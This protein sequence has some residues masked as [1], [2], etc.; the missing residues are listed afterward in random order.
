MYLVL[1]LL[2]LFL[3][4]GG[5]RLNAAQS[6]ATP[7][8]Y[9]LFGWEVTNFMSK[10]LN[11]VGDIVPFGVPTAEEKQERVLSFFSLSDDINRL[12]GELDQASAI[13]GEDARSKIG[14]VQREIDEVVSRRNDIKDEIEETIE[15][16]ISSVVVEEGLSIF[17]EF[18]FPPVDVRLS[19]PP[20]LLVTS[21]RDRIDRTHD[22]L[23]RSSVKVSDRELIEKRLLEEENL[24]AIVLNI[25]GIATYPASIPSNQPLQWTLQA[26]AHEWLHHYFFFRPLGANMFNDSDMVSL[27]ETIANLTGKEIG[28]RAY[29]SLGGEV[30]APDSEEPKPENGDDSKGKTAQELVQELREKKFDFD[31]EMRTTRLRAD[32]LLAEGKIEEAEAYMEERRKLFVENKFLIRKINQAYFAFHG[33]YADTAASVSPIGDQVQEFRS[34]QPD[35]GTFVRQVSRISSY[36]QFLD[37]LDSLRT[38][39]ATP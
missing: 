28:D 2:L 39:K 26:S 21:P 4:D 9:D 31:A 15:A 8:L 37:A 36:Q 23:L 33:T 7:Y 10:W 20:K 25:G 35:L 12:R 14:D 17:G 13:D 22:V 38:T 1:G 16:V 11:K 18:I 30:P 3:G 29:V 32:E 5:L 24:S 6:V 34:H 27:N 19:D